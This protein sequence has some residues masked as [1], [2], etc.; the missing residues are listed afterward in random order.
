M[1]ANF[2]SRRISLKEAKSILNRNANSYS[3]EEVK[4]IVDY[5]YALAELEAGH[6]E[7]QNRKNASH[8]QK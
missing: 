4:M 6:V 5:L 7:N 3:D 2:N 8:C 1:F